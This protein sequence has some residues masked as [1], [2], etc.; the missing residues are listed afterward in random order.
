VVESS[1][2]EQQIPAPLQ[3][4][5][6]R[7]AAVSAGG[8]GGG[9]AAADARGARR[10]GQAVTAPLPRTLRERAERQAGY[11]ITSK[12]VSKWQALVK[13]LT[14]SF[15]FLH[16]CR[17]QLSGGVEGGASEPPFLTFRPP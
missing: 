13:V 9:A 7:L 5:L 12:D 1:S 3:R 8:D 6:R 2:R 10:K 16:L 4:E 11:E 14:C 17:V 15:V